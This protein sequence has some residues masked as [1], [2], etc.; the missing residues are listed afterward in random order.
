MA[1]IRQIGIPTFFLTLSAAE[2]HWNELLIIL[3]RITENRT[4]TE[5]EA[6]NLIYDQKCDLIRKDLVT[7]TRYFDRRIRELFKL[8]ES[9]NGPF[10][11]YEIKETYIRIEEN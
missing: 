3:F 11:E 4:I 6:S 9:K 2:T 10:S 5:L 7:V 1:M 8:I